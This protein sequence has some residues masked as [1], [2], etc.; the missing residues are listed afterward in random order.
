MRKQANMKISQSLV[1]GTLAHKRLTDG[2]L[3]N[4]SGKSQLQQRL[5]SLARFT[6]SVVL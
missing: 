5:R 6:A 2:G 3:N 1:L 4:S